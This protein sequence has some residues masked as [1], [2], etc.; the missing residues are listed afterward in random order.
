MSQVIEPQL[1]RTTYYSTLG[2]T[3]NATSYEVHKSYLKLARLLHPDK[4]KSD[5]SEELFKAVVH[6][7]SILTDE[8][9]KLRYDR[10][11]KIKGL[12]TY[13][14]K[15]YC[16]IFKTKTK[17][18]EGTSPVL[19]KSE[20]YRRENKPYEQQPY[21]F[22][23]GKKMNSCSKSKVPIFKSFNLKS[24]QRNHY[25]SSKKEKKHGSPDIDSLFHESNGASKVRM[26]DTGS[27]D[28]NS[29]FQEIWE[30]LD[31]TANN[32]ESY[33]DDSESCLGLA[34]SD[35]EEEQYY[36]GTSKSNSPEEEQKDSEEPKRESRNLSEENGEEEMG[37]KQFKL[38][39][40]SVS[41]N[42][43]HESNLRSPFCSHEHRHYAR[44]KFE[45]R[46]QFRRSVS[47]IK[48]MPATNSTTE[49]WNIL[50]DIVEKLNISNVDDRIKDPL[51]RRNGINDKNY[52]DSINIEKLS[53]REPK[54]MKRRKKDDISL[55]ELSRSLPREKDFFMMN[56]INES[57]ESISLFK[58]PKTA[59]SHAEGKIFSQAEG[60]Y[61]KFKPLLEQYGITLQVLDLQIPE[62][63]ELDSVT[64]LKT[65][66][67]NV[68]LF[69]NQCNKLKEKLYQASLQRLS[70][71][72]QFSDTLIESQN[73]MAWKTC[74]EFDKSL[75]DK[76]NILQ[77]RQMQ[78]IRIFFRRCDGIV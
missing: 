17:E 33:R 31:K 39:K 64:D 42:K 73:I 45:C 23:V 18:S 78:A 15:K 49:G 50:R 28:T 26:T 2:L 75:M 60:N 29:Q 34:L 14:P 32:H 12:H 24:Y 9:Q 40:I 63:P 30:M 36:R 43:S 46:N 6:A 77:K 53:I 22:G 20:A 37:Y 72:M 59:Q 62:V 4:T 5:R 16:H 8:D 52:N 56:A 65:L 10:D 44:S 69:N 51:F 61:T 55:E 66:K 1:D 35:D 54:G 71:D 48:E 47:P 67:L 70:A 57:L 13:Q 38:P 74:L 27:M 25:Y 76:M 7:H 68:Q 11:L 41:S 21:G 3:S 19:R 58:K